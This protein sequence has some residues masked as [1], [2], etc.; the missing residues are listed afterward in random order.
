MIWLWFLPSI[1]EDS[2]GGSDRIAGRPRRGRADG[3][4]AGPARGKGREGCP[5]SKIATYFTFYKQ[6]FGWLDCLFDPAHVTMRGPT[7]P[8]AQ[9]I[10]RR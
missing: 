7:S 3:R 4:G 5:A 6:V 1:G 2:G 8:I 10:F 9:T